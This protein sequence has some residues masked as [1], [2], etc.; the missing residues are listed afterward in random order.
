MDRD[1]NRRDE[2]LESPISSP[3]PRPHTIPPFRPSS[4]PVFRESRE[5]DQR[6]RYT[7]MASDNPIQTYRAK[8]VR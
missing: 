5:L 1:I 7:A 8:S 3:H 6:D 4:G 2:I